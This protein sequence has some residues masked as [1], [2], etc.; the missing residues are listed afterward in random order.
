MLLLMLYVNGVVCECCMWVVIFS[1][2]SI[3]SL[4]LCHRHVVNTW[5][6][7]NSQEIFTPA[8]RLC[9]CLY[10]LF[11][12]STRCLKE[13][14]VLFLCSIYVCLHLYLA[15]WPRDSRQYT[16]PMKSLFLMRHTFCKV[17]TKAQFFHF[18]KASHVSWEI[19]A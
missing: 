4:I 12:Q 13:N 9:V 3:G 8:K 5:K 16:S 2:T 14:C 11:R 1:W 19:T 10:T 17:Q 15:F 18:M 7:I 6:F